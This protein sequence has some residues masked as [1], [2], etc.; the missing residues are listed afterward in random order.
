MAS[1]ARAAFEMP[2]LSD[3]RSRQIETSFRKLRDR[4]GPFATDS[5]PGTAF[6]L[7][8]RRLVKSNGFPREPEI[9]YLRIVFACDQCAP[10]TPPSERIN[11]TV[12]SCGT[13]SPN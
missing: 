12:L 6:D 3:N 8:R 10:S 13:G 11:A 9:V 1:V 4:S 5:D 2:S 7:R